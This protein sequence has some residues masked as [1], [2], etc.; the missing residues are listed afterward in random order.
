VA[1]ILAGEQQEDAVVRA[2]L[3]NAPLSWSSSELVAGNTASTGWFS[4]AGNIVKGGLASGGVTT[5]SAFF[6]VTMTAVLQ[7]LPMVQALMRL[8]IYA[9]LPMIVVLSRYPLSMMVVGAMAIFTVRFWS[10]VWYL[11]KWVDQN[12]I[13]AMY[14]DMNV[15]VQS[16]ANSGVHDARRMLLNVITT[17]LY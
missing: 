5:A 9:L 17:S 3:N 7:A 14:P 12:L 4:T 16:F 13:L 8:G 11:A 15:F 10:V 6:P 1:P 2:V